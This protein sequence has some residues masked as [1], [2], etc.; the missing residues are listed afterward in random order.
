MSVPAPNRSDDVRT[1]LEAA[2]CRY[3]PQRAAVFSYLAEVPRHPTA[4]DVYQ[5]VRSQLAK[6]SLATVYNTLELLTEKGLVDKLIGTDGSA[7]FDARRDDHYHLRDEATGRIQD[8][9]INYDPELLD[10]LDPKLVAR[11][12]EDG[13]KVTG[14]RLEI[15][16]RYEEGRVLRDER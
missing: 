5:A 14:Y 8:L 16:G 6:I 13:F 4:E 7:H 10:K 15:I 2:G 12:E 11:L 9:P 1:Q 3:T